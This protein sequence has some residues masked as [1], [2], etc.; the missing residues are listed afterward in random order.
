MDHLRQAIDD[1]I[2]L[3]KE[4]PDLAVFAPAMRMT[5]AIE[6]FVVS[7]LAN[8]ACA[9]TPSEEGAVIYVVVGESEIV[10]IT[11]ERLEP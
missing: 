8:A 7:V 1:A 4:R 10:R 2:R 9:E 3:R 5:P 11:L 6:D